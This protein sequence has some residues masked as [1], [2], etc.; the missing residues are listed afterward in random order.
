MNHHR[1][2]HTRRGS[3]K[4]R[5]IVPPREYQRLVQLLTELRGAVRPALT[6]PNI[7]N[8]SLLQGILRSFLQYVNQTRWRGI[9][10]ADLQANLELTITSSEVT[11]FSAISV[12][13]N[14]QEFLSTLLGIALTFQLPRAQK[15]QL[16]IIIR[17]IEREIVIALDQ[18]AADSGFFSG[19]V[20]PFSEEAE[21]SYQQGQVVTY[22]G[23]TYLVN[24]STPSGAPN[25]SADYV[26]LAAA[27]AAGPAGIGLPGP[28]GPQGPQGGRH[29]D[30]PHQPE[31]R[32][33]ADI[34]AGG[35]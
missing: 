20:I 10:Q 35:R 22:N 2:S 15:D 17:E 31:H 28:A 8:V 7:Q 30:H 1:P 21:S 13:G 18:V 9:P 24:R 12:G 29:R 23:S 33:R 34:R 16:V 32:Y 3:G 26:L 27:G 4:K 19:S 5:R 11:P 6:N 25:T 14:L